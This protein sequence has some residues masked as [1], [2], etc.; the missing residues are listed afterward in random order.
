M[1]IFFNIFIVIIIFENI[2]NVSLAQIKPFLSVIEDVP[3][4]S[5]L[6]ENRDRA[7]VF[8]TRSGRIAKVFATG[9]VDRK[10]VIG[11]YRRS[12]PQLGWVIS[13]Q[14]KFLRENEMLELIFL[15][16]KNEPQQVM[17]Y[18]KLTPYQF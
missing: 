9:N 18:F 17:I 1:K 16:L 3:L 6:V 8:E 13:S 7:L 15:T 11:F 4:M 12:L 5:G 2:Y 14:T 10:E